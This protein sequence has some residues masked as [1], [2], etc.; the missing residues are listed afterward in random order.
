MGPHGSRVFEQH[1]AHYD[2]ARRQ[3]IP[4]FDAFYGTAVAALDDDPTEDEAPSPPTT[5]PGA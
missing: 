3:L 1:A 5:G 2:T 4:P